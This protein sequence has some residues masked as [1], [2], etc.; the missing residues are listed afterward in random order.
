M[1]AA[2]SRGLSYVIESTHVW[3]LVVSH[4][5]FRKQNYYIFGD[6]K[7]NS[8]FFMRASVYV[9]RINVFVCCD[10]LRGRPRYA[11][12]AYTFASDLS[13][14]KGHKGSCPFVFCLLLQRL[15]LLCSIAFFE[16]FLFTCSMRTFVIFTHLDSSF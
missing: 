1:A 2:G 6:L 9:H 14:S 4:P 12:F 7:W 15:S 10:M 8:L 13:F 11:G 5:V 3:M 16:R